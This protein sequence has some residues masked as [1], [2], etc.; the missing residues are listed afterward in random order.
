[1]NSGRSA[2]PAG[3]KSPFGADISH[4]LFDHGVLRDGADQLGHSAELQ[5]HLFSQ[6]WHTS[7]VDPGCRTVDRH[8]DVHMEPGRAQDFDRPRVLN[9][10][11]IVPYQ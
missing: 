5:L 2:Q 11:V 8:L 6:D 3:Y 10:L 4:L 7:H 9:R 1:M